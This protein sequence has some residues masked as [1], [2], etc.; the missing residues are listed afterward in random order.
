MLCAFCKHP[1]LP[2]DALP[3]PVQKEALLQLLRSSSIPQD[4]S[5]CESAITA[6][7]AALGQYDSE[8]ERLQETL[9]L[10]RANRTKLQKH[11]RLAACRNVFSSV[12]R[13]PPELLCEIFVS[14]GVG[15]LWPNPISCGSQQSVPAG[16]A[17]SSAPRDFGPELPSIHMS[18]RAT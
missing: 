14:G 5:S 4:S 18:G 17:W 3:T 2:P 10:M 6:S 1:L 11:L 12:R 7:A 13:L 9:Q 15:P 16:L 8:I